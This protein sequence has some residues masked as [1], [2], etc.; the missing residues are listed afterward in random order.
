ML[1]PYATASTISFTLASAY[2]IEALP[3]LSYLQLSSLTS[4]ISTSSIDFHFTNTFSACCLEQA[5]K[6][7]PIPFTVRN[8]R[9]T[10]L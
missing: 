5:Q 1:R 7:F 6:L 9:F 10:D 2:I 3:L 4:L 8:P